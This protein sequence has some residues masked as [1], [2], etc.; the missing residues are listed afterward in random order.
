VIAKLGAATKGAL[1]DAKDL[2]SVADL[3]DIPFPVSP[4]KL[5]VSS[6]MRRAKGAKVV[7]SSSAKVN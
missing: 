2:E 7:R 1:S 3:G 5:E 4:S 6:L